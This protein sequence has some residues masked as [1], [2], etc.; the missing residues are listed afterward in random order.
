MPF[1]FSLGEEN[2]LFMAKLHR[3][4]AYDSSIFSPAIVH[5]QKGKKLTLKDMNKKI[6]FQ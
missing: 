5:L 6:L 4:N 2:W 3:S 1:M